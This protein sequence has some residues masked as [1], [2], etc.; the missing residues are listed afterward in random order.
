[1]KES[2]AD[3]VLHPVRMR[4]IQTLVN[5]RQL[6]VQQIGEKL[7]DV[8]QASLYRHLKKLVEAEIVKAV[9][10]HQVRGTV[11]KVYALPEQAASLSEEELKNAG[12]EEHMS[13]FMKFFATVLDD[14]ERYVAQDDFDFI[15]DGTG[16]RQVSFYANDDE[17]LDLLE[18]I[19]G[20]MMKLI[21]NEEEGRRK[22]TLTTIVTAEKNKEQKK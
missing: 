14:F 18:T 22:R 3:V 8:P 6:T 2:K 7:P 11:E 1:M 19:N 15:K 16:Y 4:I 13:F 12:A 20:A 17:Y 10:E 21:G 5:R 9:E